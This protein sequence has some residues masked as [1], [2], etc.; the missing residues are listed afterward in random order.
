MLKWLTLAV[1]LGT[2]VPTPIAAQNEAPVTARVTITVDALGTHPRHRLVDIRGLAGSMRALAE[3]PT[4]EG[5][6]PYGEWLDEAISTIDPHADH[7]SD[8][9]ST[10]DRTLASI[11]EELSRLDE[12]WNEI[13]ENLHEEA[14]RWGERAE[15]VRA[16]LRAIR[17]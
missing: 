17:G 14:G 5:S 2:A 3:R 12:R 9:L 1:V 8:L 6:E 15:E 4:F 11:A 7:R 16:R 13:R 10:R